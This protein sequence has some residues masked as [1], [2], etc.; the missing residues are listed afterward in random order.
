LILFQERFAFLACL[1]PTPCLAAADRDAGSILAAMRAVSGG[2]AWATVAA[3]RF[4]AFDQ[5]PDYDV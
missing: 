2:N 1:Y 3:E 4:M 5:R